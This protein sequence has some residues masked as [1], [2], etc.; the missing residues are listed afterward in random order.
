MNID[1]K[2]LKEVKLNENNFSSILKKANKIDL[3][4]LSFNKTLS[5]NMI[6]ILFEKNIENVNINLLKNSLCPILQINKFLELNDKIYNITIAHNEN[7]LEETYK[8]LIS[9]NDIDVNISLEF[10]KNKGI[11]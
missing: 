9:L 2:Y 3:I 10:T 6:N 5:L 1:K 8:R 7:L 4:Y 11:K